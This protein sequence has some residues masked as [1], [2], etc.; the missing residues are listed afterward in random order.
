MR[1]TAAVEDDAERAALDFIPVALIAEPI[2][3]NE[4]HW[5]K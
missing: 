4:P 5:S 2:P 3:G 1:V